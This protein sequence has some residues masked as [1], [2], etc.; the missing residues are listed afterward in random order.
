MVSCKVGPGIRAWFPVGAY[1]RI[2]M[3]ESSCSAINKTESVPVQKF[4]SNEYSRPFKVSMFSFNY[5]DKKIL[6]LVFT[7]SQHARVYK[8]CFFT[9]CDLYVRYSEW[10]VQ[11][12]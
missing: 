9:V 6:F 12:I 4:R 5:N 3:N 1:I 7:S 8:V 2:T 10:R 11:H